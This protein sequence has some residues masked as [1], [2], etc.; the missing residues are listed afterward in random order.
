MTESES[1][2]KSLLIKVKEESE[3]VGL[4]LNIEKTKIMASGPI[5]SWQIDGET[6]E[7]EKLNFFWPRNNCRLGLQSMGVTESDTAERLNWT[8]C[9]AS[10]RSTFST[11]AKWL[12]PPSWRATWTLLRWGC[13]VHARWC[14]PSPPYPRLLNSSALWGLLTLGVTYSDLEPF[15]H[16]FILP[17]EAP[18]KP[19]GFVGW[20][21]GCCKRTLA[22][23]WS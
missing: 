13:R 5:T 10:R 6:V 9:L 4:K 8:D 11:L 7:T 18:T 16:I 15:G 23:S 12:L 22:F 21:W 1:E 3:K 17:W 20:S 2:L 14:E 19:W